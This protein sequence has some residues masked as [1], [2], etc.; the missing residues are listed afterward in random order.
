MSIVG[1]PNV[2]KDNLLF[3][4]DPAFSK[5]YI[6]NASNYRNIINNN[7][8]GVFAASTNFDLD[9]GG[10][11]NLSSTENYML[12]DAN[13]FNEN[14]TQFTWS[15]W[16]KSSSIPGDGDPD[17]WLVGYTRS[18]SNDF[19]V[20][21]RSNRFGVSIN[22]VNYRYNTNITTF[23]KI[24]VWQNI[25]LVFDTV[26]DYWSLYVNGKLINTVTS[27]TS[28]IPNQNGFTQIFIYVD[29]DGASTYNQFY[30]GK[31]SRTSFYSKV[32]SQEEI[33]QNYNAFKGR[34][35]L[36]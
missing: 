11:V 28:T 9:G 32:L 20:Y 2:V 1:G 17:E 35:S 16:I 19:G 21:F 10:C 12:A 25:V 30:T 8:N 31:I 6:P 18:G 7:I 4:F 34:F 24:N 3:S 22:N 33:L 29:R 27:V 26:N 14:R 36:I 23:F 5:S 13:I 15:F